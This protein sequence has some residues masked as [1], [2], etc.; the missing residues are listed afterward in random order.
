MGSQA[1]WV[2]KELKVLLVR[3]AFKELKVPRG[4]KGQ[5]ALLDLRAY[6]G[7]RVRRVRK[8]LLVLKALKAQQDL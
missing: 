5:Q 3:K 2:C 8:A 4:F 6:K 1:Q 7:F